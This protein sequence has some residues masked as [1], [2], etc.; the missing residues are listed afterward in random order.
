VIFRYSCRTFIIAGACVASAAKLHSRGNVS[1]LVATQE[2]KMRLKQKGYPLACLIAWLLG[3]SGAASAQ[4]GS[5]VLVAMNVTSAL[6]ERVAAHYVRARRIP[7]ENVVALRTGAA[8]EVTRAQYEREI[9]APIGAWI[10]RHAMQDRI[11]YIVLIKG[12]PVRISGSAGRDGN[13]ASVDSELTLLY[14]KLVGT[15]VVSVG[16]LPNPYSGDSGLRTVRGLF[17]HADHDLYLVSRLDGFDEADVLALIDRGSSPMRS[18]DFVL[19]SK[20][21]S[22]GET[23]ELWLK[24]TADALAAAGFEQRVVLESTA[25]NVHDRAN[26]LGY[27][28]WGSNDPSIR[29]RRLGLGFVP[30]ALATMFVST[31]ARTFQAPPDGWQ[32]GTV[33]DLRLSYEGSPQSL[34]GD[35]VREGVSGVA[36]YIAEPF[37]DGTI[38][39]DIL[40]PAYVAGFNLIES[41]YIA[42]PYLSWQTVVL[43]DPLC[44]PFRSKVLTPEQAAPDL[45]SETELPK[46]FSARRLAVLMSD[47]V[48]SEVGKLLLK[49]EARQ[50]RGDKAGATQALEAATALEPRLTAAHLMLAA[51]Y[52]EAGEYDRAIERYRRVLAVAPNEPVSLNNLAYAL[53]VHKKAPAEA[54]P[55]AQQAYAASNGEAAI[56]D[57][58]GWIH[59][60]M[61]NHAEA[62]R[63]LAEAAAKA[64]DNAEIHLHLAYAYV[65]MG[66]NDAA[67]AAL[68]KS[69][70]LEATLADRDD[71]RKLRAQLGGR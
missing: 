17:S 20:G 57:T 28:S 12:I 71:V 32:P 34:I 53:A 46:Y 11:L 35:L 19:D 7:A 58:L 64:P 6:S 68:D 48:S 3:C 10:K 60:L 33:Q 13:S 63:L 15:R 65:A 5:N 70:Q 44:A 4:D 61:G 47:G 59:H 2:L 45:E 37:L 26:I 16:P 69:I 55:I 51:L 30:G 56:A 31:G 9:E 14:R 36:G 52:D 29:T 40:F 66:R 38:R 18:G 43:G 62:E 1:P 50:S 49:A 24:A 23:P 39:P 8:D 22:T 21:K 27:S 25:S 41:F 42:M 67:L 54:L